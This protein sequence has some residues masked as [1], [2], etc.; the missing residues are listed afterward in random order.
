MAMKGVSSLSRYPEVE[1]HHQMQFNDI[2]SPTP[3]CASYTSSR[4]TDNVSKRMYKGYLKSSKLHSEKRAKAEQFCC[5]NTLPHPVK[6]EQLQIF[7]V[8]EEMIVCS[9][10]KNVQLYSSLWVRLRTF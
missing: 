4:D 9:Y 1:P 2:F 5:G 6:V 7:L 3:V 10:K 8:L